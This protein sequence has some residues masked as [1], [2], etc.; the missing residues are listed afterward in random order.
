MLSIPV[1]K[2]AFCSVSKL[3][4]SPGGNSTSVP[5]NVISF[6]E[7]EPD[8]LSAATLP[9]PSRPAAVWAY[10]MLYLA[11]SNA[12]TPESNFQLLSFSFTAPGSFISPSAFKALVN[13]C[14][15]PVSRV[16]PATKSFPPLKRSSGATKVPPVRLTV[17]PEKYPFPEPRNA[18]PPC[19]LN[20][21]LKLELSPFRAREPPPDLMSV[22]VPVTEPFT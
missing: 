9:A 4:G 2:T 5:V 7:P 11:S 18:L 10:T 6:A 12:I 13:I 19:M 16:P 22:P 20:S 15:V 1:S 8:T 17:A 14:P 3:S 21:P